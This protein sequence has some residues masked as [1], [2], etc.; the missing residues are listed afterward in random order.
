MDK[1][2]ILFAVFCFRYDAHLVRDFLRNVSFVDGFVSHDDRA[3][4]DTWFSEGQVRR[5]LINEATARGAEW[6]L[7]MDPDERLEPGAGVVIRDFIARNREQRVIGGF[8]VREMW[9]RDCYRVDGVWDQKRRWGLFPVTGDLDMSTAPVHGQAYPLNPDFRK[10]LLDL[11][12]YHLKMVTPRARD[13]RRDLY[14]RLDPERQYQ[15]IGY[16]YLSDEDGMELQE[17]APGKV[18][19]PRRPEWWLRWQIQ[20]AMKPL[21]LLPPLAGR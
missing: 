11:D 1:P 18:F 9:G 4:P 20:R 7:V 21:R 19:A 5:R 3:N 10:E 16:D 8:R 6:V 17:V 13:T 2:P 15:S 14:N 12:L